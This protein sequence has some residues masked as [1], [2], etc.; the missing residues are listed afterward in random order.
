LYKIVEFEDVIRIPPA[1]FKLPL[2]EAATEVLREKYEG[3]IFENLGLAVTILDVSIDPVGILVPG[4]GATYHKV[5]VKALFFTP[6]RQEVVE[7]EVIVVAEYGMEVRLGPIDAFIHR[8]QIHEKESFSYNKE[9]GMWMGLKTGRLLRRGDKVRA[10]I[11]QV[12]YGTKGL[13][14]RVGLTM[15]QPY[16]GKLEWIEEAL[17]KKAE[18]EKNAEKKRSPS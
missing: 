18:V 4:D 10:R 2:H 11:V 13:R 5:R 7:G 12:S 8:S 3:K 9:Q 14:L 15:R 6:L 17:R 1:L 16:L